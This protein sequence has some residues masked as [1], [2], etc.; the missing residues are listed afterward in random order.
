MGRPANP[1]SGMW[2]FSGSFKVRLA[3]KGFRT[4]LPQMCYF[5]MWIILTWRQL[6]PWGLTR[7]Y[8]L[9]LK[10]FKFE[11]FPRIR[12]VLLWLPVGQTCHYWTSAL[13]TVLQTTCLPSE[14]PRYLVLSSEG[15]TDLIFS[16]CLWTSHVR[17]VSDSLVSAGF[18]YLMYVVKFDYFLLL[19]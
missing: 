12:D 2:K 14:A 4:G 17:G 11:A 15:H 16:F 10:E 3:L 9:F 8:Y 1:T 6:R 7:S 18:P 13:L 19:I 5:G